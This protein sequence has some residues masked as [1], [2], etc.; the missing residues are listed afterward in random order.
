M[1]QR[2]RRS[3][4]PGP[5]Y[6]DFANVTENT[7]VVLSSCGTKKMYSR[8]RTIASRAPSGL[9]HQ[10]SNTEYIGEKRV[11]QLSWNVSPRR[12]PII[13]PNTRPSV[14]VGPELV[15]RTASWVASNPTFTSLI[16]SR[17]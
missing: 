12:T 9:V 5:G 11:V 10:W 16:R 8:H 7:R 17:S 4:P 15:T 14:F 13:H 1:S 2:N 3:P 6:R